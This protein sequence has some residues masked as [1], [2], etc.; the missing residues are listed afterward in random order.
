[1]APMFETARE[2]RALAEVYASI[3]DSNFSHEVLAA[4]P[5]DLAVMRVSD[6]GWSD[7]GDPARV[8]ATLAHLGVES[9]LAA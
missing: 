5:Q 2:R 4:R 7:L 6:V 8:L 1:M 9:E 3:S